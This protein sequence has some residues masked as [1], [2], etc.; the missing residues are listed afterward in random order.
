MNGVEDGKFN[1][2]GNMTRA[3]F[4]SIIVRALGLKPGIGVNP[5]K[6]SESTIQSGYIR[7]AA[8]YRIIFG[9]NSSKF[10]PDDLITR[11]QAMVMISRAMGITG[12]KIEL[13]PEEVKSILSVFSDSSKSADYAE[14]SIAKCIRSGIING[15]GGRLTPGSKLTRGEAAVIIQGLLKKS[16]LI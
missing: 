13:K 11:E 5:F 6:D 3:E 14:V 9:Y 10:G 7:T 16:G 2:D 1:P 4:A 12:L 8:Q 15:Y